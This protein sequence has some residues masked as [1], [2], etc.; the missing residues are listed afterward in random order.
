MADMGAR[1]RAGGSRRCTAPTPEATTVTSRAEG[2][3]GAVI[4]T[5]AVVAESPLGAG[6]LA[7]PDSSEI[8][9]RRQRQEAGRRYVAV[10]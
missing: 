10:A 7:D 2:I 1:H 6:T 5:V 8:V 9:D 3:E 4:T